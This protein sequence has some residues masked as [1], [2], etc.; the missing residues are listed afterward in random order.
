MKYKLVTSITWYDIVTVHKVDK[1]DKKD[2][3]LQQRSRNTADESMHCEPD[4]ISNPMTI[5]F[6]L[7]RCWDAG[8]EGFQKLKCFN[9]VY[10]CIYLK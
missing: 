6:F 2:N 4:N 10:A 7:Y 8:A 3:F 5:M 1:R 9:M